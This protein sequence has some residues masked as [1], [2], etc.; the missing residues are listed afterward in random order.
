MVIVVLGGATYIFQ[1]L[2]NSSFVILVTEDGSIEIE[3]WIGL[4]NNWLI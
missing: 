2:G 1:E 3:N 4:I